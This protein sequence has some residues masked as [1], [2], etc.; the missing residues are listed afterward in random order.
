MSEEL[1]QEVARLRRVLW[2]L[3]EAPLMIDHIG[4]ES[5]IKRYPTYEGVP[6][7]EVINPREGRIR[8]QVLGALNAA[9]HE[10]GYPHEYARSPLDIVLEI[11]DFSGIEGFDQDDALDQAV[12]VAAVRQWRALNPGPT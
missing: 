7:D 12:G 2:Q 9:T 1:Q 8:R 11:H 6:W 10:N 3:I 4:L 5:I